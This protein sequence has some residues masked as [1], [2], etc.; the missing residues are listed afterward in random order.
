MTPF[1]LFRK[2]SSIFIRGNNRAEIL[3]PKIISIK[4]VPTKSNQRPN[5]SPAQ[6]FPA[7]FQQNP[8]CYH[9]KTPF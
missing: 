2:N 8:S 7:M 3:F 5:F 1:F 9:P 6:I 4:Q